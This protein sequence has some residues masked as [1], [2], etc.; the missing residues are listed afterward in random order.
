MTEFTNKDSDTGKVAPEDVNTA[1]L[2]VKLQEPYGAEADANR[3]GNRSR[4]HSEGHSNA[5]RTALTAT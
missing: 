5:S 2:T 3:A 1:G 4:A